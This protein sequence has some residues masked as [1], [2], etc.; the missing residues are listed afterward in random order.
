M[1]MVLPCAHALVR[2]QPVS[3]EARMTALSPSP[4]RLIEVERKYKHSGSPDALRSRVLATGG[5]SLG[6]VVF[7]DAYWDTASYDLAARDCWLRK[8][9]SKWELKVPAG[10]A[11]R[12]GG[13]R[14]SFL[15]IE[16]ADEVALE[17][18]HLSSRAGQ[19]LNSLLKLDLC[20]HPF[21]G[22]CLKGS[23]ELG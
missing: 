13:E 10:D 14:T 3:T 5:S 23:L 1:L 22:S 9:G 18:L 16:G 11:A 4:R 7:V 15:E 12:S 6:E 21:L 17:L 2:R 8:R 20:V 19:L